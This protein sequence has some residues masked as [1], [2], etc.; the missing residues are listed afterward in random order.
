MMT[1]FNHE[2]NNRVEERSEQNEQIAQTSNRDT[3]SRRRRIKRVFKTVWCLLEMTISVINVVQFLSETPIVR[4]IK[5]LFKVLFD[6][7]R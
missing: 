1:N 2:M 3:T 7:L 5:E 4:F 6:V